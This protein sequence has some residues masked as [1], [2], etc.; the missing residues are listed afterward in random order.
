[1]IIKPR[2]LLLGVAVA[3]L[4][5][6]M[7][8]IGRWDLALAALAGSVPGWVLLDAVRVTYALFVVMF[9]V[10][11]TIDFGYP[12]NP[13]YTIMLALF[14]MALWGRVLRLERDG[15]NPTLM[16]ATLALP[17]A[18]LLAG[19]VHWHGLKPIAAGVAQMLYIG[20]LC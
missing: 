8:L 12:T 19:L 6:W 5:V 4:A 10:P 17:V 2:V 11:V 15:L 9:V 14:V 3:A 20:V 16:A 1:M 7:L 13:A 18:A